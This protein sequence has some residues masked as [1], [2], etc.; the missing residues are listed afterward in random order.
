MLENDPAQETDI[1]IVGMVGR[2]PGA[3]NIEAFWQNLL[4]GKDSVTHFSDAELARSGIPQVTFSQKNY[5]KA[6]QVL[7]NAELIDAEF[8]GI[9]GKEAELIDPQQRL[10]LECS[11]E[12]LEQAGY[13]SL[14]YSG[15]IG[16]YVGTGMNTYLLEN[17]Q[18]IHAKASTIERYQLMLANDKD[19]AATRISYKLNLKGPSI[20]IGTACS[21]SLVATHLACQGLLSGQC[22]MAIAGAAA[23]RYPQVSGY[24]FQD[25]MILSPDGHCRAFDDSACGTILGDGVGVVLLKR[26]VDAVQDGD[27]VIAVIKGSAIN[28]DGNLKGGYTAPSVEGQTQVIVEAMGMA[29]V[30]A[31]DIS[32]VEAHGTG[33]HL[34]DPVEVAALTQAFRATSSKNQFCGIGSVKSNIGHLDVA[35]GMAGLIKV[36]LM[37]QH[38]KFVPSLHYEKPNQAIEFSKTP[39]FVVDKSAEWNAEKNNRLAGVSAFGIGGTNAHLLVQEAPLATSAPYSRDEELLVLS[40]RTQVELDRKS[41]ELAQFFKKADG[42]SLTNAAFTL[43]AGRRSFP[44]RKAF[45]SS[46]IRDA[47]LTLALGEGASSRSGIDPTLN[48]KIVFLISGGQPASGDLPRIATLAYQ[49]AVRQAKAAFMTPANLLI[50]DRLNCNRDLITNSRLASWF[51]DCYAEAQQWIALRVVPNKIIGVGPGQLV[52]ACLREE[53][54]LES[55]AAL[56]IIYEFERQAENTQGAVNS[57]YIDELKRNFSGDAKRLMSTLQDA[58]P[59]DLNQRLEIYGDAQIAFEI[60]PNPPFSSP[61]YEGTNTSYEKDVV[62]LPDGRVIIASAPVKPGASRWAYLLRAIGFAWLEGID[63][64]WEQLYPAGVRRIPLPTYPFNRKRHFIETQPQIGSF[65]IEPIQNVQSTVP[66]DVSLIATRLQAIMRDMLRNDNTVALSLDKSVMELSLDSI[67][68]IEIAAK[69]GLEFDVAIPASF[70]IEHPT[71][72]LFA[73]AVVRLIR[74]SETDVSQV[75]NGTPSEMQSSSSDQRVSRRQSLWK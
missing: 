50:A 52:A 11:W 8:F 5:V 20:S 42:L 64:G 46:D 60:C 66:A 61:R 30:Q 54:S 27:N 68:L 13:D 35:A 16:V 75:I 15:A 73:E 62:R 51:V 22:D 74:G 37:L 72:R 45:V 41:Q 38:R 33:T 69:L 53:L 57:E 71:I 24:Q 17:L 29:D 56:L 44:Y 59:A 39:F 21:T 6:N 3:P 48:S 28:N 55:A 63:I 4:A 18:S 7:K 43:S 36:V 70:F 67:S 47:T 19:F 65:D 25:G 26:L 1:A 40:A 58:P 23:V 14:R 31:E 2:F 9:P 49:Q 10:L 34:G 32:Y 12:L